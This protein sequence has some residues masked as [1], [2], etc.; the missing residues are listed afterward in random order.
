MAGDRRGN[1]KAYPLYEISQIKNLRDMAEQKQKCCPEKTAFSYP[2]KDGDVVKKSFGDVY[3]DMNVLGNWMFGQNMRNLHI[4]LIGENSYW[5]LAAFL[6]IV[7][8]GNVAV[9]IDKELPGE[10]IAHLL[11]KADVTV[12]FCSETYL[13]RTVGL[14]NVR[15]VSFGELEGICADISDKEG[16]QDAKGDGTCFSSHE[17]DMDKCCCIFFTS[18]TSGESKGVCLS[19]RNLVS[20]LNQACQLVTLNGNTVAFLPFH[21]A[22]G[23]VEGVLAVFHYGYE[24][25][26]NKSLKT[27]RSA[28]AR[29]KPQHLFL[30]PLFVETFYRQVWDTAKKQGKAVML[31]RLMGFSE[32]LRKAGIDLRRRLFSSVREAFGGNLEYII[33]GG[34][35]IDPFYIR[36]FRSWGIEILNGYGTTE[37]SPCVAVNRNHFHR[38]GTVGLPL[39]RT[40]V[41]VAKDGELWISGDIVMMGY[42]KEPGATAEVLKDNWYATGDMGYLDEDGFLTLTG[43]KKN[44]ILLSNGE[45]ISP[46]ELEGMLALDKAVREVL[47]Y[48]C[49]RMIV[50]EIYPEETHVGDEAYFEELRRKVNRGLP[51]YKRIARVVLRRDEFVKTSSMKIIRRSFPG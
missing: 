1:N 20:E 27:V 3:H 38:D 14:Q 23:L 37:C 26:L 8:S 46:E 31:R 39:P 51:A 10:T 16:G 15:I 50:A 30:V 33:S 35:A 42:Y 44:L 49:D 2:G 18:G 32:C 29:Q 4:A 45:N 25:Y 47:V 21:H 6:A 19:Q 43:R 24:N 12:V 40:S 7:N 13:G 11:K 5:W 22:F 9:P 17:I 48:E 28:L 36:E 41:R 34:A